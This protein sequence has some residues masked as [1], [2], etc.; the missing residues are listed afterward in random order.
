[1][2]YSLKGNE[3]KE[4]GFLG[5]TVYVIKGDEIHEPG[6][7]GKTLYVIKGNEIRT[8]GWFGQTVAQ[9]KDDGTIK[10]NGARREIT[11]TNCQRARTAAI[12]SERVYI[13]KQIP[14]GNR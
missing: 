9:T 4:P 1:M 14:R 10:Y 3:I 2:F 7:L 11:K 8:P 6:F 5:K 12:E 13:R